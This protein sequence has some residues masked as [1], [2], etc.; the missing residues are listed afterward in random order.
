MVKRDAKVDT[1]DEKVDTGVH[2]VDTRVD[3]MNKR[4]A[5]KIIRVLS[6]IKVDLEIIK[7][8]LGENDQEPAKA[9]ESRDGYFRAH[10]SR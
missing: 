9:N 8:R 4:S 1:S 3:E 5:K 7:R 6:E 2:K 10:W